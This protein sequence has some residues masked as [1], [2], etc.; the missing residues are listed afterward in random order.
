MDR[1][2]TSIGMTVYDKRTTPRRA[3]VVVG[4]RTRD[5]YSGACRVV[6]RW[7]DGDTSEVRAAYLT[8]HADVVSSNR[9]KGVQCSR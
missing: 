4:Y 1:R 8:K 3:G 9:A 6:V 2:L 5:A 7:E